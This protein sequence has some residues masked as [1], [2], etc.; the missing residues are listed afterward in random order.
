MKMFRAL[1]VTAA[2][3]MLAITAADAQV[4]RRAEKDAA[5]KKTD[6]EI[7]LS[8]RAKGLYESNSSAEKDIPWM[9]VV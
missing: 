7:N 6:N 2:A 5:A 4:V 8:V 9:R 1:I 3:A